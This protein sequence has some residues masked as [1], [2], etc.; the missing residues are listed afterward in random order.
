[1]PDRLV[2]VV[3]TQRHRMNLDQ[4]GARLVLLDLQTK[5]IAQPVQRARQRHG[6]RCDRRAAELFQARLGPA[7]FW[8][9]DVPPDQPLEPSV[10]R[11]DLA[12]GLDVGAQIGWAWV[13]TAPAAD[14]IQRAIGGDPCACWFVE[15]LVLAHTELE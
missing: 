12:A 7:V 11:A 14:D 8:R 4:T 13:W 6:R 9:G 3:K 15:D 5:C 1:M 10:E 2:F